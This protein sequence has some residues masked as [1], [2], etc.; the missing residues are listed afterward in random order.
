[1]C[2]SIMLPILFKLI[3]QE[4]IKS[5]RKSTP[6]GF[7]LVNG[8]KIT[9][10][11]MHNYDALRGSGYDLI[12]MD[13]PKDYDPAA[14]S[15]VLR[16]MLS[17]RNGS[18]LAIGTPEGSLNWFS[19]LYNNTNWSSHSYTSL[20]GGYIP[21]SEIA[22]AKKDMD[23]KTFRQEYEASIEDDHGRVWYTYDSENHLSEVYSPDRDTYLC[24][25]F[26]VNPMSVILNQSLGFE[27][28]KEIF[29]AV[30]EF[31]YR[32]SNTPDTTQ[33]I[34][35]FLNKDKP[36]LL[37]A[38]GDYT[39]RGKHASAGVS[40]WVIIESMLN[41]YTG[42]QTKIRNCR[43]VQDR[44]NNLNS[45]FRSADGIRRQYVNPETCPKL[46]KDLIRQVRKDDGTLNDE[47]GTIGHA[48]DALSYFP[49]NYYPIEIRE[50]T[51][52]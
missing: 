24:Y 40:N 20:Q 7:D 3:P 43:A 34:I 36:R 27:N 23:E 8:S 37:Q 26:N 9:L 11:G 41:T 49:F 39:G 42:F 22:M 30:K 44:V 35:N 13:E 4:W 47:N 25:D 33:A 31:I 48:S 38:T 51:Y 28:G 2:K 6:M 52:G 45:F 17:D 12:V 29:C 50:L 1:M 46:H 21:E 16:P 5:S 14:Y 18:C 10:A 15:E 19:D 32:D